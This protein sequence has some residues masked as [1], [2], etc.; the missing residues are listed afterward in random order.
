MCDDLHDYGP[1]TTT[2]CRTPSLNYP[3]VEC[4]NTIAVRPPRQATADGA[5]DGGG[6]APSFE[7]MGPSAWWHAM[8]RHPRG[9]GFIRG[10]LRQLLLGLQVRLYG[11]LLHNSTALLR[12]E[13]LVD[14]LFSTVK[15]K[16]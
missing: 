6:G 5:A 15:N 14:P 13:A 4:H 11:I 16:W 12:P 3:L 8:R 9:N 2:T 7:V 10:L 1:Q